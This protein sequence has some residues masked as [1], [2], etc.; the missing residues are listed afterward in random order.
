MWERQLISMGQYFQR[1]ARKRMVAS[2][3]TLTSW[4]LSSRSTPSVKIFPW[5]SLL[6]RRVMAIPATSTAPERLFPT[7]VN[8]M[9]KKSCDHL[10]ECVYLYETWPQ[11]RKWTADKKVLFLTFSLRRGVFCMKLHFI[12]VEQMYLLEGERTSTK[13]WLKFTL[14]FPV[15]VMCVSPH[16]FCFWEIFCSSTLVVIFNVSRRYDVGWPTSFMT[17]R[18]IESTN[19]STLFVK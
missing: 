15:Y 5:L 1:F 10:E 9:T 19:T 3:T 2:T 7:S 17:D 14:R 11:V 16:D 6:A 18:R 8:T 12:N 13:T 4:L